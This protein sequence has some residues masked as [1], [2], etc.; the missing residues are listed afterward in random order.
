MFGFHDDAVGD[1]LGIRQHLGPGQHRSAGHAFFCQPVEPFLGGAG[2][3]GFL[4]HH[5]PLVD[6]AL[7]QRRGFEAGVVQPLRLVQRSGQGEPFA[8]GLYRGAD[9]TGGGL[10]DQ[11]DE[12]GGFLL[13]DVLADKGL[14]AHVG[15]PEEGDDRIQHGQPDMLALA[16]PFSGQQR[17]GDRLRGVI[18]GQFVRKDRAHQAGRSVSDPA[19]MV[20]RPETAWI[21][22]SYTGFCA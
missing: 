8:V 13:R 15:G 17:G 7:A 9:G 16:G 21:S 11:V 4:G 22:G 14:A 5:Q 10:I 12:T 20:A 18:G 19:W 6:V 1:D 3:Q 2:A